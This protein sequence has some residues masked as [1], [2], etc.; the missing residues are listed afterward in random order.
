MPSIPL[1]AY[2]T[3]SPF[4][5][6]GCPGVAGPGDVD[7]LAHQPHRGQHVDNQAADGAECEVAGDPHAAQSR[8]EHGGH[9]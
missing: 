3:T 5:I 2:I 1:M 7:D 8:D 4:D 6:P 9:G